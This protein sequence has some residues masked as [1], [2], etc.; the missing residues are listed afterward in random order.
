RYSFAA[1]FSASCGWSLQSKQGSCREPQQHP[2]YSVTHY[3][4]SFAFFLPQIGNKAAAASSAADSGRNRGGA[5]CTGANA[6]SAAGES[7]KSS[8]VSRAASAPCS[9]LA[10]AKPSTGSSA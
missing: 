10:A 6:V 9:S 5:A 7:R 8:A 1:A 2:S 4:L 3:T